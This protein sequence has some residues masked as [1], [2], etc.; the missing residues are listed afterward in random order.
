MGVFDLLF[1]LSLFRVAPH[2]FL[3][4]T[5]LFMMQTF[6]LQVET[7]GRLRQG[8]SPVPQHQNSMSHKICVTNSLLWSCLLIK[9][10]CLQEQKE[11]PVFTKNLNWIISSVTGNKSILMD[12]Y[13]RL[14]VTWAMNFENLGLFAQLDQEPLSSTLIASSTRESKY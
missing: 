1:S 4:W 13:C 6:V 12:S 8:Q 7:T 5:L 9:H 10:L 14:G 2:T 3:H 11:K